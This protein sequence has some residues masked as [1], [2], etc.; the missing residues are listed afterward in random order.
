M[1]P[2][3]LL[4]SI[5]AEHRPPVIWTAGPVVSSRAPAGCGAAIGEVVRNPLVVVA[6]PTANAC[7][8][9]AVGPPP[10]VTVSMTGP[11]LDS[12]NRYS[13]PAAS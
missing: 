4:E 6:L 5:R 9:D 12:A 2:V 1:E 13:L 10:P 7:D 3:K 8:T 11:E